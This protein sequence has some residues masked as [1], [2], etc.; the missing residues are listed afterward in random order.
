M[1]RE[2]SKLTIL[3]L[4]LTLCSA[5]AA[6]AASGGIQV[7][8]SQVSWDAAPG[9]RLTL[10]VSGP[11]DLHHRQ[12]FAPGEAPRF[13]AFSESG[14]LL[15]DGV[16]TWELT[17]IPAK[18]AKRGASRSDVSEALS[19][20]KGF[21]RSG[22]FSLAGGA[23]VDPR[24]PEEVGGSSAVVGGGLDKD[25]QILDD[26]IVD[27]SLCV[28][29]DCVNGESFGFDTIRMKENNVRLRC[30]DTS[31]SASFP[32]NDW[33]M[34]C[35]ET[36]NGGANK[37]SIDDIDG[38]R[39]PF[40]IEAGARTNALYV[41]DGGRI[42]IGTA[43]P[44]ANLHVKTGNTPTLRLEQDGSSGFT[45]QTWD[46]AGNEANFFIRDATSGSTLPFRVFP[47]APSN[48]LTIEGSTG[49]IGVGTTSP[50][51]EVHIVDGSNPQ[52]LIQDTTDDAN[53][54]PGLLLRSPAANGGGDWAF[55]TD[56]NGNFQIDFTLSSGPELVISDTT[57]AT[58]GAVTINGDL[59]VVG[60][61]ANPSSRTL[62]TGFEPVDRLAMLEKLAALPITEWVYI[63]DQTGRRHV[64]PV[65]E[66]FQEAFG[67]G[68]KGT[69]IIPLDVQGV[70]I[71]ALQ[72]L[73][74]EVQNRDGR[75]LQLEEQ[76]ALLL[77]RLAKIE[78]L[79]LTGAGT[80]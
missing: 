75:I 2:S 79:L 11:G 6:V 5:G 21:V 57:G 35:N 3:L 51:A 66:D 19:A 54:K 7:D 38:A 14:D 49:D 30:F 41:D 36:S 24:V 26:L 50:A 20:V 48:A 55:E 22:S 13:D 58:N 37:F 31:S 60:T 12:D 25:Q 18:T 46:L 45:A 63:K 34:T 76:N 80:E 40:T 62:K 43:T 23:F 67:L 77:E 8:A 71:A 47:G 9:Y 56:N 33:Q 17:F 27:G 32:S 42:G 70:T 15:A 74:D 78:A 73:Y 1:R 72:G 64:G 10:S 28:G 44:V 29:F 61:F 4:T 39:T 52:L 65:T 68:T 59:T 53:D 16:Y 69:H